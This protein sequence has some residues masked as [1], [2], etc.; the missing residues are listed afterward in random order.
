MKIKIMNFLIMRAALQ[1]ILQPSYPVRTLVMGEDE[2]DTALDNAH[3][4]KINATMG[5][6]YANKKGYHDRY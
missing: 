2:Y 3:K 1:S 6:V 4:C 5:G